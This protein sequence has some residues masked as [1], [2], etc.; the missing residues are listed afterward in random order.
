MAYS[1]AKLFYL[2]SG[3]A[4]VA[5]KHLFILER[6]LFD[7]MQKSSKILLQIMTLVSSENIMVLMRCLCRR[8]VTYV[9]M[10]SKGAKID[11]WGTPCF[12]SS[13]VFCLSG[14]I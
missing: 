2:D 8:Q 3:I 13:F 4:C 6:S 7:I 9:I 5:E 12:G 10:K 11:P 14:R 1:E